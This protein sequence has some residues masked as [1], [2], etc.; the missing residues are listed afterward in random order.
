MSQ[1]EEQIIW[2]NTDYPYA[3]LLDVERTE[4]FRKAIQ[5]VVKPGDIVV[6][7]GAGTGILCVVLLL[8]LRQVSLQAF[9]ADQRRH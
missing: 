1:Q 7:V 2:S 8:V 3:C 6:E 4:A 9:L 5:K